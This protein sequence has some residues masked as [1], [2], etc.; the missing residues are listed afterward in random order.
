[1]RF[2]RHQG[3]SRNAIETQSTMSLLIPQIS[4]QI[5]TVSTIDEDETPVLRKLRGSG[6][7]ER[8]SLGSRT[9]YST[10]PS[11]AVLLHCCMN[12]NNYSYSGSPKEDR[13]LDFFATSDLRS[14]DSSCFDV[15]PPPGGQAQPGEKSPTPT[16]GIVTS[17]GPYFSAAEMEPCLRSISEE[18]SS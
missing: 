4:G 6:Q 16:T 14:F 9:C 2:S 3:A 15:E 18:C 11:L 13:R 17:S 5:G 12:T 10:D 8:R 7:E 1:M